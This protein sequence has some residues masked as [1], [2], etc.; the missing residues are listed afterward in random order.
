[1]FYRI[2]EICDF[3]IKQFGFCKKK[4]KKKKKKNNFCQKCSFSIKKHKNKNEN[5]ISFWP[6]VKRTC[7]I[8]CILFWTF[9]LFIAICI[10]ICTSLL[11]LIFKQS[12]LAFE[13]SDLDGGFSFAFAVKWTT[14]SNKNQNFE[15]F[16]QKHVF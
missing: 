6:S 10:G 9:L 16:G 8:F 11:D 3:F 15:M 5:R 14:I 12:Y 4:K 13:C 7:Q 1:M 2:P